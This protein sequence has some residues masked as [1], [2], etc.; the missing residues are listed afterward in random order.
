[1]FLEI[2]IGVCLGI[3]AAY[4]FI[5]YWQVAWRVALGLAIICTMIL[6][7]LHVY[8]QYR[9]QYSHQISHLESDFGRI[10]SAL[11]LFVVCA[12]IPMLAW[13]EIGERFPKLKAFVTG[14]PPWSERKHLAVR[15]FVA[16]V[17]V[18]SG[19]GIFLGCIAG[20]IWLVDNLVPALIG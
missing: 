3:V 1:M 7:G 6:F 14:K 10:V 8:D 13:G 12:G 11:F 19:A 15:V 18:V 4:A 2:A 20:L 9:E 17:A 16:T 5:K